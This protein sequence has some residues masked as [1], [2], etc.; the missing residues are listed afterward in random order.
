MIVALRFRIPSPLSLHPRKIFRGAN[1]VVSIDRTNKRG[2][3]AKYTLPSRVRYIIP[4]KL[5]VTDSYFYFMK[6]VF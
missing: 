6:G 1:P 3:V 4:G 2:N 5:A